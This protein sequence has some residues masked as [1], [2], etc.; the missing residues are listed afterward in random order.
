MDIKK[1]IKS[2]GLTLDELGKQM[3]PQMT[4]QALSALLK[5]DANPTVNKL[6][7]IARV[8]NM[9]L[10]ELVADNEETGMSTTCPHCGKP[11]RIE[12]TAGDC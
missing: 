2:K 1:K 4:Q 11:I 5:P 3:N 12:L 10:S 6:K 7:E 8:L 9:S